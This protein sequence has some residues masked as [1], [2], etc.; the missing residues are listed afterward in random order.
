MWTLSNQTDFDTSRVCPITSHMVLFYPTYLDID[1]RLVLVQ[2]FFF[3]V[4]YRNDND[5]DN[6]GVGPGNR[7]RWN[8]V[9]L[10]GNHILLILHS[11]KNGTY[12]VSINTLHSSCI[13]YYRRSPPPK[14][15]CRLYTYALKIE[16]TTQLTMIKFILN[17]VYTSDMHNSSRTAVEYRWFEEQEIPIRPEWIERCCS[18]HFVHSDE[19]QQ[20]PYCISEFLQEDLY[21]SCF[22]MLPENVCD[23]HR[24]TLVGNY[25][26][27]VT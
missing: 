11:T 7:N 27:Q 4:F 8:S 9:E 16:I 17:K 10:L 19:R 26:V 23:I 3:D 14:G 25:I 13:Y 24:Q 22:P 18:T 6:D 2:H 12:N 20:L 1:N 5:N 15:C 21:H